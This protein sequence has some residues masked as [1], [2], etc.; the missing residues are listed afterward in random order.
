ML[1]QKYGK[2]PKFYK[3][4]GPKMNKV[5]KRNSNRITT[6]YNISENYR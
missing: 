5:K 2:Y 3:D 4:V 1:V 6:E